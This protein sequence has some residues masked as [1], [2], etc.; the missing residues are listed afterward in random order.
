MTP[1][2]AVAR[3]HLPIA[4]DGE[5]PVADVERLRKKRRAGLLNSS[6]E[7]HAGATEN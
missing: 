4:A 3:P 7:E 1:D 6:P 2:V 5:E